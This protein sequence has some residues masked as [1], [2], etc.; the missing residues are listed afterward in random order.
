MDE[1]GYV[2]RSKVISVL[3]QS[4]NSYLLYSSFVFYIFH[5]KAPF[6][7]V[8]DVPCSIYHFDLC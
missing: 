7:I 1:Q 6:A 4:F 5:N 2:L 8:L 3:L